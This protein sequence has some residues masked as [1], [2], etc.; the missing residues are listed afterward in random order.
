M[1]SNEPMGNPGGNPAC[2]DD[3]LA[4]RRV[5]VLFQPIVALCEH[6]VYGYEAL[7]RGPEDS[8]LHAPLPLFQAAERQQRL[9]ELELLARERAIERFGRQGL[10]GKLFLNV[11]PQVLLDPGFRSGRTLDFLEGAG[12]GPKQVVIEI[13]EHHP[14]EDF[15]LMRDAV[16]HYREMGF[17]IAIDDLGAGYAGLR[18]W[19]ELSPDFVKIDRHF[20]QDLPGSPD[21]R[22]FVQSIGEIARGLGCRVVA[23][24]VE[25]PEELQ[26][27]CHLGI[28][29]AQGYHFAR[30]TATPNHDPASEPLAGAPDCSDGE[31]HTKKAAALT[32][33]RPSLSPRASLAEAV[34]WLQD[35]PDLATVAVVDGRRPVGLVHR[36]ELMSLCA[37][38]F[39]RDLYG[40]RLLSS[41]MHQAPVIVASDTPVETL[42]RQ[43]TEDRHPTNRQEDFIVV[44]GEGSYLGMGTLMDLLQTITELQ[45]RNARHANPLTGLPGNIPIE[46]HLDRLLAAEEWFVAV[47]CDLDHFKPFNDTYGYARGDEVL[48]W[49]GRLIG[50]H[51][52]AERDF[53]G[54][55]GGDDFILVLHGPQWRSQCQAILADLAAVRDFYD[56]DA[57]DRGG[58]HSHDRRGQAAFYPFLSLS[59]GAV[60][61]P[62]G[63][64]RSH[65]EVAS[66]ATELKAFAKRHTGSYLAVDQRGAPLPARLPAPLTTRTDIPGSYY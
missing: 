31:S 57:R 13:T 26:V 2:L 43:I 62:A 1:P 41:L 18:Q 6:A 52:A 9:A 61:V 4:N 53:L 45:V 36:H 17:A 54:H 32:R 38:R 49:L 3:I 66:R 55:V 29:L 39:G 25:T 5:S 7:A 58:I 8:P 60:P 63:R 16:A 23:E 12:M 28:H 51:I 65:A 21:K 64:F 46:E 37:T 30:P 27:V 22:Q 10:S 44:D 24:G 15:Q 20:I 35:A 19:S 40:H 59:M 48:R 34:E 56:P 33:E 50:K 47:Y 42:S 14:I 11:S